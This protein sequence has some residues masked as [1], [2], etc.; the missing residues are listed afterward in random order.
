M[1]I[2]KR[3]NVYNS[4]KAKFTFENAGGL[5]AREKSKSF[6]SKMR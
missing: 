4:E 1:F 6:P 5:G 2:Q 3:D